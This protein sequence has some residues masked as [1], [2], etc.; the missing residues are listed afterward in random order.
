MSRR[1]YRRTN[2]FKKL[3]IASLITLLVAVI[4]FVIAYN[5]Y[6]K[7]V[8]ENLQNSMLKANDL[9]DMIA[10]ENSDSMLEDASSQIGKSIEESINANT[11]EITETIV[12]KTPTPAPTPTPT[13]APVVVEEPMPVFVMP[14]EGEI[15][16]EYAK[17]NLLYSQTLDEWVTHLG[18]DIQADKTAVVKASAAGTVTAIKND[19]RYGLTVVIEHT[20]GF[21]TVYSNLLTAEYVSIGQTVESGQTLGTVGNTATFEI[22][23]EYHLHF[24]ILE[25]EENVDPNLYLNK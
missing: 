12:P 23:D 10:N 14:V 21:K 2:N 22:L 15:T 19:P 11:P 13:P 25:N 1:N 16:R 7:K 5:S 18:I 9:A 8:K 24:E 4:T 17:E 6:N 3:M 20:K